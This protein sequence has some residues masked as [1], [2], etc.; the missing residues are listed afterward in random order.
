MSRLGVSLLAAAYASAA[1]PCASYL[2]LLATVPTCT[3]AQVTS[4]TAHVSH[5]AS[6]LSPWIVIV[7]GYAISTGQPVTTNTVMLYNPSAAAPAAVIIP[8]LSVGYTAPK[9]IP[10]N[11]QPGTRAEHSAVVW[12]DAVFIYGGQNTDFMDDMWRLCLN[13]GGGSGRWDQVTPATS[14][15]PPSRKGHTAVAYATNSTA[16]FAMVFGGMLGTTYKDTNDLYFQIMTKPAGSTACQ[17]PRAIVTWQRV[18]TANSTNGPA[19]R[20]FH[21]MTLNSPGSSAY[22]SCAILYGGQSS[23]DNTIMDDLW[24]LCP[25]TPSN[26]L[27]PVEQQTYVWTLL[28]PLGATLPFPRFGHTSVVTLS[29]RLVVFGGSYRFPRDYLSD[30]W[31]FNLV[32][33]RWTAL[34]ALLVD[35]SEI[36]PRRFHTLTYTPQQHQLVILGGLDRYALKDASAIQ[37]GYTSGL[38]AAGA[39]AMYCNA[40]D[41]IACQPCVAGYFAALGAEQCSVCPPGTYS[42]AGSAQCSDCPMG[43]Y[44]ALPAAPDVSSCV[45]CPV[46]TF[47]QSTRATSFA[48]C[49]SCPSGS[50]SN[51]VGSI[52]CTPCIAG[53]FSNANASVCSSCAAGTFSQPA[54]SACANCAPGSYTPFAAMGACLACPTGMYSN[55]SALQ[56]TGCP[57][58]TSSSR[59]MG[60][61]ADCAAC[62][63]GTY[64][65]TLGQSA[66]VSCPDGSVST[67]VGSAS[68]SS[69]TLCPAGT[70]SKATKSACSA[71]PRSTFGN[72]TGLSACFPC[73]ANTFTNGTSP[74]A[75]TSAA[76]CVPCP[77]GSQFD[78]ATGACVT[79]PPG[80]HRNTNTSGCVLCSPGSFTSSE[81]EAQ[82]TQ[83]TACSPMQVSSVYGAAACDVCGG[84]SYS[85]NQ[86]S[87]CLSCSPPCPVG[88]NGFVCSNLGTCVYGGCVCTSN[89]YGIACGSTLQ[90]N[91]STTSGVVFFSTPNQTILYDNVTSNSVTLA[92]QGGCRGTVSV[93]VSVGGGNATA[94]SGGLAAGWTTTATFT[95]QQVTK[96]IALPLHVVVGQGC[97][98]LRLVLSDPFPFQTTS[99]VSATDGANVLLLVQPTTIASTSVLQVLPTTTGYNV[100]VMVSNIAA[101]T[102]A[103]SLPT[104]ALPSINSF[105]YFDLN[106]DLTV[107]PLVPAMLAFLEVQFAS[108]DWRFA[109]NMNATATFTNDATGLYNRLKAISSVTPSPFT[110]AFLN[111]TYLSSLP[112][113]VG[114][115]R[116]VVVVTAATSVSMATTNATAIRLACMQ[117]NVIP[118]FLTSTGA[119]PSLSALVASMGVGATLS[120]TLSTFVTTPWQLLQT[121][122]PMGFYATSNPYALVQAASGTG[123]VLTLSFRKTAPT[124]PPQSSVVANVLGLGVVLITIFAFAPSCFPIPIP[125]PSWPISTGWVAP[126]ETSS[127]LASQ[128]TI[129]ASLS[130]PP[131][132]LPPTL[133]ALLTPQGPA[134][135]FQTTSKATFTQTF[136][137]YLQ[138][139]TPLIVR[140]YVNG[141]VSTASI[142][143]VVAGATFAVRTAVPL[144]TNPSVPDW[145]FVYARVVLNQTTTSL[146]VVVNTSATLQ[147]ANLGV[148][149]EPSFACQCGPGYYVRN[150]ECW[151]C[152]S[153]FSCGGGVMSTC[154]KQTYSF[155]AFSACK[156]CLPGWTCAGGLALPCPKGTYTVDAMT[157]MPC[158][159]G[160]KCV[161][162]QK[163]RLQF[164]QV[165]NGWTKYSIAVGRRACRVHMRRPSR[166]NAVCVCQE[167]MPRLQGQVHVR[168]AR[169]GSRPTFDGITAFLV[170]L[171][172]RRRRVPLCFDASRVQTT[173]LPVLARMSAPLAPRA[174]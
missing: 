21:T 158:P 167:R 127:D 38:C 142:E 157:C 7:G 153:G 145:Q 114:A 97:A 170:R 45:R 33:K 26:A 173:R 169:L 112:W 35:A 73:P 139:R 107:V 120:Y 71:C 14:F 13:F 138:P 105:F 128:W 6:F 30:A 53:T 15:S 146:Q 57:V 8:S 66:C 126:Y 147:V 92:R 101:T 9:P 62:A 156:P 22:S 25:Q 12:D 75:S 5:T 39:I 144:T 17:T 117:A 2:P 110:G 43:T 174:Q 91:A 29:N 124:D 11:V 96:T 115:L 61:L 27:V 95:D 108:K 80:T 119:A 16:M 165:L 134:T 161:Q 1:D 18:V 151:R 58:G 166:L 46:G 131:P 162:G 111:A 148:Y 59:V 76:A 49:Q 98:S 140:G 122:T 52:Q 150:G 34:S 172:R 100:T 78:A 116:Q 103:V 149:P 113:V 24:A 83:C 67:A 163:Y 82:A 143:L 89:A 87:S 3:S 50:F 84:G 123:Q 23:S 125:P 141:S 4:N 132:P 135:S 152:P 68:R 130:T 99:N 20:S 42:T 70:Y 106:V 77:V 37:C 32:L 93:V 168:H 72:Q 160:F 88:R 154:T 155:G 55:A 74:P 10:T 41:H 109:H 118:F 133:V 90:L 60:T 36:P 31:E 56:C 137:V 63:A 86:W 81:T 136:P 28:T 51:V 64:A 171:D 47:S 48:T 40:T 19:P 85:S 65:E 69:C 44:N 159:P 104:A 121:A 94:A 129:F 164:I 102:A 54:A 79:C